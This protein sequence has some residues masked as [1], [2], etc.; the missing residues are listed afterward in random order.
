MLLSENCLLSFI[1]PNVVHCTWKLKKQSLKLLNF[2]DKN[3]RTEMT[4][5]LSH[6]VFHLAY[7]INSKSKYYYTPLMSSSTLFMIQF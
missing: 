5:K 1:D 4:H 2:S 6:D 3:L 7:V